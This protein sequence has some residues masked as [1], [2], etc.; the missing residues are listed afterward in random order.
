M[1]ADS[2]SKVYIAC[3]KCL[4]EL[5]S[6]AAIAGPGGDVLECVLALQVGAHADRHSRMR[7]DIDM[8]S[9]MRADIDMHSRMRA[10]I[11]M[12]SRMHS[13]RPVNVHFA[14]VYGYNIMFSRMV[15]SVREMHIPDATR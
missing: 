10:D 9:R 2:T 12:H 5:P 1:Q 15:A 6:S 14:A 7:A 3:A 4:F 11:D 8:H 13:L